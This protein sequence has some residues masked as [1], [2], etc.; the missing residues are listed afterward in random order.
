MRAAGTPGCGT[1]GDGATLVK[2][3]P[4]TYKLEWDTHAWAGVVAS[5]L[6][7]VI[8]YCGVFALF[9]QELETWQEPVVRPATPGASFDGVMQR[10]RTSQRIARGSSVGIAT[11]D[12]TDVVHVWITPPTASEAVEL[13]LE[14]RS[15]LVLPK[16]S[17]LSEELYRLHFL[18]QLPGGMQLAGLCG[19]ALLVVTVT[20]LV[21]H[22]KD[23]RRQWWRFRPAQPLRFSASDAHKVLGVFGLPF[24]VMLSWSGSVICLFGLLASA[25][26]PVLYPGTP[27]RFDAMRGYQGLERQATGVDATALS[28]DSLVDCARAEV[29]DAGAAR[30]VELQHYGDAAAAVHVYFE[31]AALGGSSDVLVDAVTGSVLESSRQAA[32]PARRFEAVLFDLHFARYG[33]QLLKFTY[34]L[35]GLGVCAVIVSGNVIWL[36]RRDPLRARRG[37]RLLERATVGV[38]AGL[39]FA[40]AIYLLANRVL[41]ATL[42]AR[43]DWEFGLFLAVWAIA[44][45]VAFAPRW[46]SRALLRVAAGASAVAFTLGLLLDVLS[47]VRASAAFQGSAWLVVDCFLLLLAAVSA[48]LARSLR[49]HV[50][51]PRRAG[52]MGF[53]S[54]MRS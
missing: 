32:A 9:R 20:G 21:I 11:S 12:W 35:L 8:F 42:P 39:V 2:L 4:R 17:R 48:G 23:L 52:R 28:L 38:C 29:A 14:P 7:F 3:S 19:V 22:L 1:V 34:A 41:P 13:R 51:A 54:W 45:G 31:S 30:Y 18:D 47:R 40:S 50:G 10:L 16:S 36:E 53:G 24:V 46:S 43:P 15:G 27:E 26:T 33:G 44:A 49:G 6:L 25:V 37:H 5:L